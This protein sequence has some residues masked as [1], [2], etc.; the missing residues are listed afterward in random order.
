MCPGVVITSM[1]AQISPVHCVQCISARAA[2][3]KEDTFL[4]RNPFSINVLSHFSPT[5]QDSTPPP[6]V[7]KSALLHVQVRPP[8][9]GFHYDQNKRFWKKLLWVHGGGRKL[10]GGGRVT[11]AH[12][13]MH[14]R[15]NLV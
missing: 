1:I 13:V 12:T 3:A 11:H 14:L 8:F 2:S 6:P 10:F 4:N 15:G 5:G 9:T 7:H